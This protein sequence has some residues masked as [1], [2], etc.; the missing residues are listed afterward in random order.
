MQRVSPLLGNDLEINNKTTFAAMEPI[1]NKQVGP[2]LWS[3]GQSFWLQIEFDSRPYQIFWQVGGLERGP[4][5]LVITTE[6]LFGKT[7]SG[8][9]LENRD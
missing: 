7:S 6:E 8:S 5:S 1:F 9:G 2:P 4:L 3:S